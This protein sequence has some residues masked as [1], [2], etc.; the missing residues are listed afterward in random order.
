MFCSECGKPVEHGAKFCANCGRALQGAKVSPSP[1]DVS[2]C[3]IEK[4]FKENPL[5]G[6]TVYFYADALGT[7]GKFIA[8]ESE[9]M[10]KFVYVGIEKDLERIHKDFVADLVRGGWMPQP[11]RGEHWG[12]LRFRK[13]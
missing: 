8:G 3:Q 13:A 10:K 7:Q 1:A 9:R 4:H 11:D 6:I 5:L 2:F 12:Q